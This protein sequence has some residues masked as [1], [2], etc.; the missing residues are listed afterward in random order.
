M[1]ALVGSSNFLTFSEAAAASAL[2]SGK[3]PATAALYYSDGNSTVLFDASG[4]GSG[5]E[6]P[7]VTVQ[8]MISDSH[9][10]YYSAVAW[11]VGN[12]T[13]EGG[14]K[15][16]GLICAP[17][18][19]GPYPV[20]IYNHGGTDKTNGG[21]IT[22]IVT[23]AGWT[24]Q[25]PGAPDGLGQCVDWAKRGWIFATSSYRGESVNIT[26]SSPE[27]PSSTWTSEG[28]VEFC[29]GEVTDVLAFTDL[30]VNHG[31]AITLGSASE[32]VPINAN[33]K[34]LMYGYSHGGCIT[35][36]AVEQGAPVT[37]FSV[38]EGFTDLRL[39]YLTGLSAGLSPEFA[40][41]GS[42]AFQPGV[43][44]YLPDANGVMGYNWRSAHYFAS[45]GDLS[46]Q[47]FKT[48]P[49][50]ILHGDIDAGNPVPLNQPAE[51]SADIQATNIFVG[52]NGVS[53][54]SS[55]PCID[56]PVGAPLPPTLTAPNKSC[57]ISFTLMNTGDPCVN[58]S[59]PPLE[60]G[61]CK[62]LLLPLTPPPGQPQ[63]LHYLAVYHNMNHTNGGLAI[64]ETFNRFASRTSTD[65]PAATAC[66]SIAPQIDK[67]DLCA[68]YSPCDI[69]LD[70]G[71]WKS[72]CLQDRS[73]GFSNAGR[74]RARL[75]FTPIN[76]RKPRGDQSRYRFPSTDR[77]W[78]AKACCRAAPGKAR[79]PR[80]R[81]SLRTAARGRWSEPLAGRPAGGCVQAGCEWRRHIY[82]GARSQPPVDSTT[83]STWRAA[84][85]ARSATDARPGRPERRARRCC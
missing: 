17:T 67:Q 45:R 65:N 3:D 81:A 47:K 66:K 40:A 49:I 37:A 11:S 10:P 74:V 31:S 78:S 9:S 38:I 4:V 62:V 5:P 7:W 85:K 60:L 61:L 6:T 55:L 18:T 24:T 1:F 72:S 48:M 32:K 82:R 64:K 46:I 12:Y 39:T 58:G 43:S 14:K 68:A 27:F 63:Q 59:A 70:L 25:P 80:C 36:R 41:I 20:V 83:R 71:G 26:S 30:L 56:G 35:Y 34:V 22:G 2:T 29:M 23:A 42:G 84:H 21:N 33:G 73:C 54:P 44:F 28:N 52:P 53:P 76:H 57:P 69:W 77:R 75:F 19:G 16:Y 15:I 79:A 8:G 13:V 51:I 50:L